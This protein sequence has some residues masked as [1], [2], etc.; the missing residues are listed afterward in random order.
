MVLSEILQAQIINIVQFVIIVVIGLTLTKFITD[1]LKY[2]FKRREVQK[3][4]SDMGYEAPLVDL[5]LVTIRYLLYFIT[6]IIALSQFGFATIVFN[7]LIIALIVLVA[8]FVVYSLKDVISNAVA[9]VFIHITKSIK[10]GDNITVGVYS[11]KVQEITLM[12]TM[13]KDSTGRTIVIPNANLTRKEIIKEKALK[14][15]GQRR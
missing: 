9:G 1:A 6:I 13:L 12:T 7:I 4:I 15:S 2:F 14:K 10:E 5:I 8:F 11:G 3:T